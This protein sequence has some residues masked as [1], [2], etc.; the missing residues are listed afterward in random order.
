MAD[1]GIWT[2]ICVIIGGT[3]RPRQITLRIFE[4]E[5]KSYLPLRLEESEIPSNAGTNDGYGELDESPLIIRERESPV[6]MN[7][8]R[9]L[10]AVVSLALSG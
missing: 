10:W 6:W 9:K 1:V 8:L 7:L 2:L 3:L 4:G 5:S